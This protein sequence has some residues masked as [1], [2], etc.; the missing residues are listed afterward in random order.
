MREYQK[1]G[2]S[3][4]Y[5]KLNEE[6]CKKYKS[7]ASKFMNRKIEALK[8][9]KPGQV[10]RILKSMGAQPGECTEDRTFTL[11][12]HLSDGLSS[13]E[14]AEKIAEYF[15][16]ISAEYE[17][18]SVDRLPDRVRLRLSS[19]SSPPTISEL[20]CYE[21]ITAAKKP[22]SG[23][24]GD[25]PRDIVKEFA[26]ELARPLKDLFNNIVQSGKWPDPWK[27]EYVT[28][29]SKIPQPETEDDLRPIAL[30]SF[31]SKVMEQFVVMWLLETVGD[32]LDIRQYGGIRGNSVQHYLIELLNFILYNQDNTEPTAILA[33]LVDFSKAFN[34]QDHSILITKLSDMGVPPWL[35]KLVISFLTKRKMVVRY[36]GESSSVKELPGGGPQGALL[37]LLLFLV[38]VND[39][40]FSDQTNENGDLITCKRRVKSF[41]ELHLKYV[42]D[43]ALLEAVPLKTK[44]DKV[45][46]E[47]PQPYT[48]H[49]RSGHELLPEKSRVFQALQDTENYAKENNMKINYKK[50]KLMIFNP[51]RTKDFCPK[52]SF[53]DNELEIVEQTKLLG[54]I[55]RSD[56]S[57]TTNTEYMVKRANKKLWC[58]KRLKNLGAKTKDLLEVYF[59][60]IRSLL[61]Y[62][63]AVWHP[64]LTKLDSR[65][66]ERVQ[67][68]AL[69]IILGQKYDSYKSAL[70]EL[71]LETLFTRRIKLCKNFAIKAQKHPKFTKW[72]KSNNK[73]SVTRKKRQQ[74]CEVYYR[75]ERFKRSPI[76]YLTRT[77]N[78]K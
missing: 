16:A 62:S 1:N 44:L 75:T 49:M 77:L 31:F 4:K 15:A 34:R 33:C 76:S 25:L 35:L 17:P 13:K 39:I 2:K 37:G 51:S 67:K 65:K 38:L 72:F 3:T 20:A 71:N 57:W 18:L 30:T 73:M 54:L 78:C 66:I 64:N 21:K 41:N 43:L 24:P 36:K 10:F 55:V 5:Q 22:Q 29:I 53:N 6:F 47:T 70:L 9:N 60:Q 68:S 12:S 61:E 50:T 40:G 45:S 28:P 14:S 19:K 42:D 32:K 56:L 48:Y 8:E 58:L 63:V 59:K 11:Q 23:V 27:V 52:F 7:A 74:F 26:V 69:S 46:Q